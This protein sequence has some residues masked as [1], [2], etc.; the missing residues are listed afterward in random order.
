MNGIPRSC[1]S[2]QF[3]AHKTKLVLLLCVSRAGVL[4]STSFNTS[5][6]C[7]TAVFDWRNERPKNRKT[8]QG[9]TRKVEDVKIK[10]VSV[11]SLQGLLGMS[12]TCT[13]FLPPCSPW[14]WSVHQAVVQCT[15]RDTKLTLSSDT[16]LIWMS[17][18]AC[19]KCQYLNNTFVAVPEAKTGGG[20]KRSTLWWHTDSQR[21]HPQVWAGSESARCS[22][23]TYSNVCL[24][25]ERDFC[26]V[27][28]QFGS[29]MCITL[30]R[31]SPAGVQR[32]LKTSSCPGAN[33]L[34]MASAG[35]SRT[36]QNLKLDSAKNSST[37][38]PAL[39][40]FSS[41]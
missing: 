30:L 25:K 14:L 18:L 5:Q 29:A 41:W 34:S 21:T 10:T 27:A 31:Q 33:W 8:G 24:Q 37:V 2:L 39:S 36:Y 20:K 35:T 12:I 28:H 17:G 1:N 11:T 19:T 32:N 7:V 23:K 16:S 26:L 22:W 40:S 15:H 38:S 13:D 6:N 9:N 4:A 3:H